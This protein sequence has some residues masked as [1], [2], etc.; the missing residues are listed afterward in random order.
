MTSCLLASALSRSPTCFTVLCVSILVILSSHQEVVQGS[1]PADGN[2]SVLLDTAYCASIGDTVNLSG[3]VADPD[4]IRGV[5]VWVSFSDSLDLAYCPNPNDPQ[6]C[7]SRRQTVLPGD[8][9]TWFRELETEFENYIDWQSY[10]KMFLDVKTAQRTGADSLKAWSTGKTPC[11]WVRA[12]GDPANPAGCSDTNG[13]QGCVNRKVVDMI[14]AS[15][16]NDYFE[17]VNRV[18]FVHRANAMR[19]FGFAGISE[20][21]YT[22]N[23]CPYSGAGTT[24]RPVRPGDPPLL[25]GNAG[26]TK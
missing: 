1:P 4:T 7:C 20:T 9:P 8:L 19:V 23:D 5:I 22:C 6:S 24:Q 17:D 11:Y 16:G 21:S 15:L 3:T 13:P 25:A 2:A 12:W 10:G 26:G 14:G 18:F